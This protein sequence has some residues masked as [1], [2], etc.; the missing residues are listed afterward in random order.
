M[1]IIYTYIYIYIYIILVFQ[2]SLFESSQR[3]SDQIKI[4]KYQSGQTTL[5]FVDAYHLC[6]YP[7][8]SSQCYFQGQW[9]GGIALHPPIHSSPSSPFTGA[10]FF[11]HV[12][13]ENIKFLDV[14]NIWDF[15]LFI[16]Q[17]ISDK[18]YIAFSEFVLAVI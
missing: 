13:L 1:Y 17:D 15:R 8:Q 3:I 18:K 2:S 16:E 11:F 12:K 7:S 10:S 14:N 9:E 4:Q 5:G 6:D